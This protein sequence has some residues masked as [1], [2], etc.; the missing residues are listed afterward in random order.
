[1]KKNVIRE[2]SFLF[3]V[4][5]LKLHTELCKESPDISRQLLRSGTSIGANVSEAEHA[6]SPRDFI[7][8]LS[9]SRKEANESKY[10]LEL[11]EATSYL[12]PNKSKVLI[13]QVDEITKILT[14]IIKTMKNK[15]NQN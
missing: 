10:W 3:S 2:K 8:K 13:D 12:E 11:L 7:N 14:S 1:M 6:Q 5:I 4:E 15:V 9:I